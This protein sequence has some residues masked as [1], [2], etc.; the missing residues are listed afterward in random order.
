LCRIARAADKVLAAGQDCLATRQPRGD[1][2]GSQLSLRGS[3]LDRSRDRGDS[4]NSAA[5]PQPSWIVWSIEKVKR[6]LHERRIKKKNESPQDRASRRTASATVAIAIL[7]FVGG[8]VGG[9]QYLIFKGQLRI[10]ADQL[11]EMR[12]TGTQ[13]D[14]LII[15]AKRSADA[16]NQ[17]AIAATKQSIDA[18]KALI[19]ANRAWLTP[20]GLALDEELQT[21]GP[22]NYTVTFGNVGKEPAIDFVA[23]EDWGIV[24]NPRGDSLYKIFP[25]STLKDVCRRTGAS[26]SGGIQYPSGLRDYK[27]RVSTTALE[28]TRDVERGA[29]VVFINGCF[30]YR[31]FDKGNRYEAPTSRSRG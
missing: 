8:A 2:S 21:G 14:A 9:L 25:R 22:L 27:Y 29:K 19:L 28:I 5:P 23:Q 26:A 12:S 13:T 16:A 30:A 31:T 17:A 7:T 3:F 1:I 18:E 15:E 10:M 24:D 20:V 4:D 11:A 6:S